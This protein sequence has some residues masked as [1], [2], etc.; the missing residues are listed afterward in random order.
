[1]PLKACLV[2][3]AVLGLSVS[4]LS[5][6]A[7]KAEISSPSPAIVGSQTLPTSMDPLPDSSLT[8][9]PTPLTLAQ[10][11]QRA[12]VSNPRLAALSREVAA[13]EAESTQAGLLP[14]PELAMELE[15]FAGSG[16]FSGIDAAEATVALSQR[17]ELGGK[18]GRRRA[19]ANRDRAIAETDLEAAR[20][21]V[22]AETNTRFI[23][24]LAAR[25]RL[26]LAAEQVKVAE[27]MLT[28]VRDRISAGKT[29]PLDELRFRS[30]VAEAR[31]KEEESRRQLALSHAELAATWGDDS[32][33]FPAV[34]GQFDQLK[35]LPPWPEV[36][37]AA[38]QSPSAARQAA[39]TA[40]ALDTV[41]L[42]K[43]RGIPDLTVSLGLRNIRETEDTALVAGLSLPLPLFDR[44]QGA[45]RAARERLAQA[46]VEEERVRSA[47]M[48]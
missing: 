32:P 30:L 4:T 15:N 41:A 40:G 35:P 29:A 45:A 37:A 27:Q 14:N 13:R 47:A 20:V 42:E 38:G 11:R 3:G 19:V 43:S 22:L 16:D 17:L 18:R 44:N 28:I 34:I 1:M 6:P 12:L 24:A 36:A 21:A 8:I 2:L 33:D 10:A 5:P 48:R 26:T 9:N 7:A 25:E 31:L 39:V 23:T 46:R